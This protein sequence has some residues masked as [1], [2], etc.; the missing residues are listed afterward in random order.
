MRYAV[1][2]DVHANLHALDVVLAA[3]RRD[4]VDAFLCAGDLVGYGAFPN[5]CVQR[6]RSVDAV[7]VAGN[8]DLIATGRLDDRRT[9]PAARQSLRW[10]RDVLHADT[11]AFLTDLPTRVV[12]PGLAMTH[13]SLDDVEEYVRADARARELLTRLPELGGAVALLVLGHTHEPWAVGMQGGTLLRRRTGTCALP[14][15]ESHLLN[16]G[17]VGQS[18]DVS[19]DA[20]YLLVDLER[21]RASFRAVRYDVRACVDALLRMGLPADNCHAPPARSERLR[22][23]VHGLARRIRRGPA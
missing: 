23:R 9:G 5:E 15:D 16:P 3:A 4:G 20:R 7:C 11:A 1:L 6:L 2:S 22:A 13:G 10:T 18:R 8:H 14:E 19:P 12:M 21:R 17:S